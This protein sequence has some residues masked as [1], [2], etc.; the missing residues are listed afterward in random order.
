MREREPDIVFIEAPLDAVDLVPHIVDAK[1]KPPVAIYSS[2]RD[3][4]NVLGLAGI[5][6]PGADVPAKFASWYPL[7]P[8]S[9]E[10]IAMKEAA[11]AG[12]KVVF[13]DLPHHGQI[14]SKLERGITDEPRPPP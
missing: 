3:D 4:D 11:A 6:S 9:P 1:T 7:L 13:I 12:A 2:Y 8:Y 14:R 5:E 10:Y